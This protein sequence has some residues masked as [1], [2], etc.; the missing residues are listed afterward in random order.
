MGLVAEGGSFFGGGGGE[1]LAE[2][3]MRRKRSPARW[4]HR[5][6]AVINVAGHRVSTVAI[7]SGQERNL[8]LAQPA[9]STKASRDERYQPS[10]RSRTAASL[11]GR[12][13]LS[14]L[15]HNR[16]LAKDWE[17]FAETPHALVAL[18]AFNPVSGVSP[19]LALKFKYLSKTRSLSR[20]IQKA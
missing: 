11:G 6:E 2:T 14:W 20:R 3:G 9:P 19:S 17:Y 15:D 4:P 8:R 7:G 5:A 10:A 1:G 16:R 12:A 13:H 18:A